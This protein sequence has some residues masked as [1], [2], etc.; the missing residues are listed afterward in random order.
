MNNQEAINSL[1][2]IIE[3]WTYK[4]TEVE[5]AKLAISA[6]ENQIPNKIAHQEYEHEG[7][8]IRINGIDGVPYDLC[9]NCRTNLCTTGFLARKKMNYCQECGQKLDWN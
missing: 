8:M 2:N 1:K 4:P 9:P 7:K 3:Y 5:A 6:I